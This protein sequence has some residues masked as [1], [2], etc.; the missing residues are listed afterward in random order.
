MGY[1]YI[2]TNKL[3]KYGF[4][5]REVIK[6]GKTNRH[7]DERA[8]ELSGTGVPTP[9]EVAYY[10]GSNLSDE[11]ETEMHRE[12]EAYRSNKDREFFKYP[13][14]KAIQLLE[15]LNSK[16][17]R[18]EQQPI[19]F[20]QSAVKPSLGVNRFRGDPLDKDFSDYKIKFL[21]VEVG[22]PVLR[23]KDLRI[24][25]AYWLPWLQAMGIPDV[26]SDFIH[27]QDD[28]A[29]VVAAIEKFLSGD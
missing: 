6:I 27:T 2:L 11:L 18:S 22:L 3:F 23:V 20:E 7:P 24:L 25:K 21:M 17:S 12:L 5:R 26:D 13:V 15:Q 1:V 29:V 8:R 19:Q 16:L 28:P 9:F 4:F 14:K 10:L